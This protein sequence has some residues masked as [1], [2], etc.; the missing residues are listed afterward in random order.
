[1]HFALLY[2]FTIKSL[3]F[4]WRGYEGYDKTY[5]HVDASHYVLF[6]YNKNKELYILM[7]P[8]QGLNGALPNFQTGLHQHNDN[9]TRRWRIQGCF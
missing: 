3:D 2:I 8:V 1:M 9:D 6:H 7:N 5:A 4:R